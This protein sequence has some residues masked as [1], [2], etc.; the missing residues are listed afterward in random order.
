[1]SRQRDEDFSV[2]AGE[3]TCAPPPAGR[4]PERLPLSG[5][6]S[7]W[8]G[9]AEEETVVGGEDVGGDDWVVWFGGSGHFL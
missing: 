3:S 8:S 4:V 1:L 6:V 2:F 9:D 5:E 7:V